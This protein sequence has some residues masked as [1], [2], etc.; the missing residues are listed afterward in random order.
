MTTESF[1]KKTIQSGWVIL[2]FGFFGFLVWG[3][4]FTLD[5]GVPAN[6]IVI[7]EGNRKIIQHQ[8]G[9]IIDEISVKDGDEVE[10]GQV[11]IKLNKVNLEAT[12]QSYQKQIE[13]LKNSILFLS[14]TVRDKKNELNLIEKRIVNY[15]AL[16]NQGFLSKSYL[17]EYE[18]KYAAIKGEL[19]IRNSS[20]IDAQTKLEDFKE[21]FKSIIFE[22]DRL[23]IKSPTKG[24]VMNSQFFTIGG[25]VAPGSKLMEIVPLENMLEVEIF[26]PVNLI[27]KVSIGNEV[28]LNFPSLNRSVTPRLK[29][30]LI[31]ISADRVDDSKQPNHV[32]FK[33]KAI[34]KDYKMLKEMNIKNGMSVEVFI[35]TGDRSLLNYL[36]K[37]LLDRLRASLI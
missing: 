11:L 13:G 23:D 6:G 28:V 12:F 32:Y 29:G 24:I 20:L 21:R 1:L 17:N 22:L 8:Q 18:Q 33:A 7:I 15:Q 2:I 31:T 14:E 35:K 16:V 5:Q 19:A 30:Q 37:P 25:V 26:I 4:F 10:L 3:I 36:I 34:F 27:D 9:G